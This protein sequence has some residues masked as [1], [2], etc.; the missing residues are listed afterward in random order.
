MNKDT[1]LIDGFRFDTLQFARKR[2]GERVSK[3]NRQGSGA[4]GRPIVKLYLVAFARCSNL[5]PPLQ[6]GNRI[7]EEGML[8]RFSD[9]RRPRQSNDIGGGLLDDT[10]AIKF[11]LTDY[12]RLPR[13][14]SPR[15]YEHSHAAPPQSN[16]AV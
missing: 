15:Q 11:Q 4:D 14:G 1:F 7:D 2:V 5:P 12:R 8:P 16:P 6:F 13:A 9:A 10:E 3:V